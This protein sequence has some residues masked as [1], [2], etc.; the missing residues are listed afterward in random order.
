[1]KLNHIDLQVPDVQRASAVFTRYFGLPS[2]G[3]GLVAWPP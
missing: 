3:E 2:S 1:M